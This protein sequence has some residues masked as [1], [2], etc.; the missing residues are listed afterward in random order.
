MCKLCRELNRY[1]PAIVLLLRVFF[2]V[3]SVVELV[4]AEELEEEDVGLEEE[5]VEENAE[6][7]LVEMEFDTE[8]F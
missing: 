3:V 5:G 2:R 1:L 7:V 8:P 4:V 6:L